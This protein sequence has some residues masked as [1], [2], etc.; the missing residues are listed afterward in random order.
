MVSQNKRTVGL[1]FFL[2]ISL[3]F[4]RLASVSFSVTLNGKSAEGA[5]S[6]TL[7]CGLVVDTTVVVG[8]V[9]STTFSV[10]VG[11]GC[12][13]E[14]AASNIRIRVSLILKS[15]YIISLK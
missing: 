6:I 8:A 14:K 4:L 13:Q 1:P 10:T 11:T 5:L 15:M 7:G 3:E 9:A 12:L 2:K